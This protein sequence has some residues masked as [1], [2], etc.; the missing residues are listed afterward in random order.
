MIGPPCATGRVIPIRLPNK[1]SLSYQAMVS[2]RVTH[3]PITITEG[4]RTPDFRTAAG[5][6]PSVAT[7]VR[8]PGLVAELIR[9]AGVWPGIPARIER[10]CQTLETL[11]PHVKDERP[12]E[13]GNGLVVQ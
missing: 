5:N 7:I 12:R 11:Q 8:C 13:P 2:R 4:G 6:S 10:V 3:S 9:Q 1:G